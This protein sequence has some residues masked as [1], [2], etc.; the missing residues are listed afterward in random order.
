VGLY[1]A[2]SREEAIRRLEPAH[3]ERYKWFA[4]FGFVRYADEEGRPWGTP[5]APARIP[6][7][8]EG[9]EQK[10]WLV[11]RP[12][13]AIETIREIEARYPGLEQCMIHWAEGIPPAE[14]HEQLRWFARDVMPAFAGAR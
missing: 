11:G 4:P 12:R 10:A 7:L 1:L 3:D 8:R 9:V 2:D 13:E 14:F 6:T 5:G